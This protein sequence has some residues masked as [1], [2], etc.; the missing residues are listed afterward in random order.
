MRTAGSLSQRTP[1]LGPSGRRGPPVLSARQYEVALLV[2]AGL[3]NREIGLALRIGERTVDSHVAAILHKLGL[4]R[5]VQLA[6]WLS[7]R[8]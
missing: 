1:V 8:S 6:T 4:R 3:V 2:A 7:S 5:R